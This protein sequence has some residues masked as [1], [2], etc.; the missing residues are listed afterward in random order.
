MT[1]KSQI[2]F[3]LLPRLYQKHGHLHLP[4]VLQA[5]LSKWQCI[6]LP[7][8]QPASI[9]SL[10]CLCHS[11]LDMLTVTL[12]QGVLR[13]LSDHLH[14]MMA[15]S[16]FYH[17]HPTPSFSFFHLF[18]IPLHCLLSVFSPS[19][20]KTPLCLLL[21]SWHEGCS[22]VKLSSLPFPSSPLMCSLQEMM[23]YGLVWAISIR[24]PVLQEI[25]ELYIFYY[26]PLQ[27]S[28]A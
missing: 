28:R 10:L 8:Q 5:L 19:A 24:P 7:S 9:T 23:M 27:S 2:S 14:L 6:D 20:I 11:R 4:S 1:R 17:H 26:M 13:H 16:H 21:L 15:W 12:M 22:S 3:L 18:H 25:I